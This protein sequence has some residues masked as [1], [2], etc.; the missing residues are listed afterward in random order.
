MLGKDMVGME[1]IK[2]F[3]KVQIVYLIIINKNAL[4]S[5][6]IAIAAFCDFLLGIHNCKSEK[7]MPN[8]TNKLGEA[9]KNRFWR[10]LRLGSWEKA[11]VLRSGSIKTTHLQSSEPKK[12]KGLYSRF[13]N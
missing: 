2:H 11:L 7:C 8:F 5:T 10:R 9:D 6:H 1:K 4:H 12:N 3:G 13:Q